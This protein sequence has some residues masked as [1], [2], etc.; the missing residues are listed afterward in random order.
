MVVPRGPEVDSAW[1]EETLAIAGREVV[2][3]G[4]A[5]RFARALGVPLNGTLGIIIRAR[6]AGIIPAAAP[7]LHDLQAHGFR[8]HDDVI[9]EALARTVDEAWPGSE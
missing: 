3:D 8:L 4:A 5:P 6:R 7:V 9:R 2:D 1:A